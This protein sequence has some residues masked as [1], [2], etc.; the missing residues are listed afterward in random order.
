[1]KPW[2][3]V[4]EE[5]TTPKQTQPEET[6]QTRQ[7]RSDRLVWSTDEEKEGDFAGQTVEQT[8]ATATQYYADVRR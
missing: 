5:E 1:M 4:V 8:L 7:A 6:K 2:P 3:G